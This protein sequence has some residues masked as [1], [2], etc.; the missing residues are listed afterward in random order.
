MLSATF[1][2]YTIPTAVELPLLQIE[3]QETASPFTPFGAKG[4]GESGMG[5][6]LGALCGA[7]EESCQ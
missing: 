7:I 6:I 2:D 1:M 4:V 5:G 3:H